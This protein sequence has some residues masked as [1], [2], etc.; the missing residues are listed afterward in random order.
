MQIYAKQKCVVVQ[1]LLEM[2]HG[3]VLVDAVT[4]EATTELVIHATPRHRRQGSIHHAIGALTVGCPR[5]S[6]VPDQKL[7]HHGWRK[8]WRSTESTVSL[9]EIIQQGSSSGI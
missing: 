3:P 7:Q 9:I 2:G 1:H 4:S 5:Q 8:F 6:L